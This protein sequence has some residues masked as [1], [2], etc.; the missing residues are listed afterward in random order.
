MTPVRLFG[1][2]AEM[3]TSAMWPISAFGPSTCTALLQVPC[4][5]H[6]A[7]PARAPATPKPSWPS[8][9]HRRASEA[10]WCP[11]Q[12]PLPLRPI[13]RCRPPRLS[14][15]SPAVGKL[16]ALVVPCRPDCGNHRRGPAWGAGRRGA[17]HMRQRACCL[18]CLRSGR[19]VGA[20]AH[21]CGHGVCNLGAEPAVRR[22]LPPWTSLRCRA[23]RHRM[24]CLAR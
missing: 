2:A 15:S 7:G 14:S 19:G 6:S 1:P 12:I 3:S 24:T 21:G 17:L 22:S 9:G 4:H 18:R 5:I 16:N 11:E 23:T 20:G 8:G 13:W 10:S